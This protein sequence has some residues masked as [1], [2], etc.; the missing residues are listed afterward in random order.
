MKRILIGSVIGLGLMVGPALAS[1]AS[2]SSVQFQ[3]GDSTISCVGGSTVQATLKLTVG[4][5]EVVEWVRT[6]VGS[7]PFVDTSVGG[8]LGIQE[9]TSDV[10]ASVMCPPNTGTYNLSVR[11]AGIYGGIHSVDGADNVVLSSNFG[12]AIRTVADASNTTS[13]GSTAGG[14]MP[15]W[16]AAL[17]AALHPATPA[18]TTG[19]AAKC[20]MIAPYLDAGAYTYSSHGVQLQSVLL[21][22]NPDSIPAL[23]AGATI[24][25]GYRGSQT[26][27]ALAAY[28]AHYM[29]Q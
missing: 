12:S 23:H 11:G 24:P 28:N 3:N 18:P 20:A 16:L 5:G 1:A 2:I 6:Q 21:L 4:T 22:D 10:S 14:T 27:A 9:G 26:N 17:I 8:T 25:M 29:C 19:N 7:Q 15:S 13:G